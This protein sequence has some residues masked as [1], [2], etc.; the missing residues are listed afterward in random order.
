[1]KVIYFKNGEIFLEDIGGM[2]LT[3]NTNEKNGINKIS[4]NNKEYFV[5]FKEDINTVSIISKENNNWVT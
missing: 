2:G 3:Y 5:C 4:A 1:M